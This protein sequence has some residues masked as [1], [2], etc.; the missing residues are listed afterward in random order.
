MLTLQNSVMSHA[1]WLPQSVILRSLGCMGHVGHELD[2]STAPRPRSPPRIGGPPSKKGC[3]ICTHANT[4][5]F[6]NA[7]CTLV[8]TKCDTTEFRVYGA[9]WA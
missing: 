1:L 4:T 5:K 3:G 2:M 8:A 9:C 7:T 6:R